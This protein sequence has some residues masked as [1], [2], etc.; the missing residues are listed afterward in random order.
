MGRLI[1]AINCS[2]DGYANDARGELD[3]S[4]PDEE[5]H[6]YFADLERTVGTHL[7]GRR[8]HE[9]MAVWEDIRTTPDITPMLQRFAEAWCD[10]DTI[11][12]SRTLDDPGVPRAR[13][14][15]EFDAAEVARLKEEADR[16]LDIGGPTLAA[17]ALRAGLVDEVQLAVVPAIIG[18]GT[19]ALPAGLRLDLELL[20]HRAFPRGTVLLRYRVR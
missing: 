12:Y 17:H 15:R 1:Y 6:D 20:E 10:A 19:P 11:V 3:W 13:I 7:Y 5:L 16:D 4:E 8:M 2:L 18:G 9:T 14:V